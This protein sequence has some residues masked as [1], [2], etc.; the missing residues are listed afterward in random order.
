MTNEQYI[1]IMIM[2]IA[3]YAVLLWEAFKGVKIINLLPDADVVE[4][5]Q[6][7]WIEYGEPEPWGKFQVWYWKCSECGAVGIDEWNYCPNCG[8]RMMNDEP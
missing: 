3:I 7:K 8:A 2:L 5:K 6:G 4:Q 1:C